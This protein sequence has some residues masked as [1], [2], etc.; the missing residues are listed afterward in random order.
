MTLS[1]PDERPLAERIAYLQAQ[2]QWGACIAAL[3]EALSRANGKT[4][5]QLLLTKA[6]VLGQ[7]LRRPALALD[8][9]EAAHNLAPDDRTI[10]D[11][12]ARLRHSAGA[13][14]SA[15]SVHKALYRRG[16][17]TGRAARGMFD[18]ALARGRYA[19]AARL[20]ARLK[21]QAAPAGSLA[22]DLAEIALAERDPARAQAMID[23]AAKTMPAAQLESVRR[24]TTSLRAELAEPGAMAGRRHVAISG[25]AYCG[26][27]TLGVILGSAPGYAFAGE[28]HWLTNARTPSLGLESILTTSVPPAQWPIACRVCG[29]GCQC[30]NTEFRLSLAKDPRGWYRK[31]AD[32]L[33]VTNV[34]TADKNL[35]LYWE[36]DPLFRFDHLILYKSPVQHLRSMLKQHARQSGGAPPAAGWVGANLE[37]WARKYLA[38]LKTIRQS[39]A[40]VVVNWESFVAEPGRHMRRLSSLL[41]VPLDPALLEHIRLSHFIGGNTGVDVR[42]LSVDP[43]LALRAS[44]APPLPP[45]LLEEALEHPLAAWV[46]R[47]LDGEYRRAF[48]APWVS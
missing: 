40:R 5:A 35:Q 32:R 18:I 36:R 29:P 22:R 38:Y 6:R 13:D 20:S 11:A 39:G 24:I 42:G 26:S 41:D 15:F 33:A 48:G 10:L 46:G 25:A 31:I 4:R 27:T 8:A 23:L 30:F 43:R 34:V 44:N 12:L 28:T 2:K 16:D 37:R 3:D 21:D 47:L 17:P 14:A 19:A 7:N 45:E 9:I 1:D